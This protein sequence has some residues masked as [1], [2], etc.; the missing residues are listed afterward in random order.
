MSE[1]TETAPPNADPVEIGKF[2][3]WANRWWDPAGELKPL[4]QMNPRRLEYIDRRVEVSGKNCLDVGCGGGLLTEGLAALG[5]RVTGIDLAPASLAV[6]RLHLAESGYAVRYLEVTAETLAAS[7]AG[8]FDVVTCLEVLEHVPDPVGLIASCAQ[9]ARPGGHVIFSTINRH[10]RAFAMAIVGAEYVL[11]MLPK[12]T[13]DYAR[14]IQ[15]AELD[16]WAR[17]S[18]LSLADL[19]GL[20]YS[21]FSET[22]SLGGH[23]DVNYLAHFRAAEVP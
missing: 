2:N 18:G 5:A 3:D 16:E 8:R 14:F 6:A 17:K 21:P 10:P 7:E 12:G 13:H 19:T 15:P 9:L 11:G 23:V 20:H 22:F 4:H 1:T